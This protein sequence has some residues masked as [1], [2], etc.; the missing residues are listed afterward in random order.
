MSNGWDKAHDALNM[1]KAAVHGLGVIGSISK[2]VGKAESALE[3]IQNIVEAIHEGLD[4]KTSSEVVLA[5]IEATR[6]AL[7]A[8]DEHADQV[9]H[10]KFPGG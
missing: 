7:A 3:A 10:D 1:M 4:G 9:L 5:E 8:N 6:V 2:T